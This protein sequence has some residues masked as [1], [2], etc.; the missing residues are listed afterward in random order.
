MKNAGKKVYQILIDY[1]HCYSEKS[2]H[3][4]TVKYICITCK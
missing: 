3:I 2:L 1:I 4:I